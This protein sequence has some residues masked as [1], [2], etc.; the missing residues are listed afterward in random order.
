MQQLAEL[1]EVNSVLR[2]SMDELGDLSLTLNSTALLRVSSVLPTEHLD[3]VFNNP[4]SEHPLLES[5]PKV[6]IFWMRYAW[7]SWVIRGKFWDSS[8]LYRIQFIM[9]III[10]LKHIYL[11]TYAIEN[12]IRELN[13]Y[14]LRSKN[15]IPL[16]RVN[17]A[18]QSNN[19][20]RQKLTEKKMTII[21]GQD[22]IGEAC[23][24]LGR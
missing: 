17:S 10:L 8:F 20:I 7:F 6:K 24:M 16:F 22:E 23:V 4:Y 19:T 2:S 5:R 15:V 14:F 12:E 18:K 11:V 9:H 3:W 1:S 13:T 21:F